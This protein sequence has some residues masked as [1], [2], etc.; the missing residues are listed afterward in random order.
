MANM[1]SLLDI[2]NKTTDFFTAKNIENA[3]LDAQLLIG[4]VLGLDRIELYLNYDRPLKEEELNRC[5]AFV[6]RR[7]EREP[8]QHIL[9]KVH[10]RKIVI[11]VDKRVLIPRGETELLVDFVLQKTETLSRR[12]PE[13]QKVKVLEVGV[14]SGAIILSLKKE[15]EDLKVEGVEISQEALDCAI[16]NGENLGLEIEE[17]IY[18]GDTFSPFP[19]EKKWHVIV[20]NPPYVGRSEKEGLQPEVKNWDPELALYGGETGLEYPIRLMKE[21]FERLEEGGFL[22]LEIGASQG[23]D[24]MAQAAEMDWK[25]SVLKKDYSERNRFLILEKSLKV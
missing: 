21:S 6:K 1:P 8:L 10:F 20:S 3:R 4:D 5:R 16:E 2:L 23:E 18:L 17:D 14:G 22:L 15:K 9:G 24:L 13:E 25:A 12:L 19:T 7:G 11:N